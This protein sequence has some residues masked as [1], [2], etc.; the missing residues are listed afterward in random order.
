MTVTPI[1]PLT[2]TNGSDANPA[3]WHQLLDAAESD[4]SY[5]SG[6]LRLSAPGPYRKVGVETKASFSGTAGG[7]RRVAV[8][9]PTE[10]SVLCFGFHSSANDLAPYFLPPRDGYGLTV[11][12]DGSSNLQR[13]FGEQPVSPT[14]L[15]LATISGL[16]VAQTLNFAQ[17]GRTG[18]GQ[19]VW[20]WRSGTARP[21]S[22]NLST[23]D[24]GYT[25]GKLRVVFQSSEGTGY[26]ELTE[27]VT[28]DLGAAP[29]TANT[30]RYYRLGGALV[31]TRRRHRLSGALNPAVAAGA[32]SWYDPAVQT[33]GLANFSAVTPDAGHGGPDGVVDVIDDP[34]G[35]LLYGTSSVR[36]VLRFQV[37][38]TT[39]TYVTGAPRAQ[40]EG[41]N[42]LNAGD[43]SDV[44]L[45]FSLR[46]PTNS[47]GL[48]GTYFPDELPLASAVGHQPGDHFFT[49]A[50][51]YG[52][53]FNGGSPWKLG[54]ANDDTMVFQP[55]VISYTDASNT[56][57]I[58]ASTKVWRL[59]PGAVIPRN[60]WLDFIWHQ[61]LATSSTVGFAEVW[62]N[63]G[64]G[65]VK[66]TFSN[67]GTTT[68]RLY[69]STLNGTNWNGTGPDHFKL[70]SYRGARMHGNA[71]DAT[72]TH[73]AVAQRYGPTSQSV[74]PC[75]YGPP[76]SL[77]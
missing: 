7:E 22:P 50:E 34:A 51:V 13:Y 35:V 21:A 36:K 48:T 8:L 74:D 46:F 42:T 72:Y 11:N 73:F 9:L 64:S 33:A 49:F 12:R 17:R 5:Q 55:P 43:R 38:E 59:P 60:Q 65:Y 61:K 76:V 24:N 45:G 18:G 31:A 30:E 57:S 75:T 10:W 1:D 67:G 26:A 68:Q 3:I 27:V 19:D 47:G 41:A 25:A 44:W 14:P 71:V 32:G 52:P 77:T 15:A 39:G 37:T 63:T 6:R 56:T 69:L 4:T 40:V 53:P 29:A 66:L 58:P 70:A 54:M 16:A 28:D 62:L 23:T 2:G 20:L